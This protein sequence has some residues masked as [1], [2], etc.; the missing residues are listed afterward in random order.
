MQETALEKI[1][2]RIR[3]HPAVYEYY[4]GLY[5]TDTIELSPTDS[6]TLRIKTLL[7]L[8]PKTYK[9][10]NP[11]ANACFL[12]LLMPMQFRFGRNGKKYKTPYRNYLDDRRQRFLARELSK[13]F[14][15]LFL[16][17]VLAFCRAQDYKRGCQKR[18]I[19]DFI[20]CCN[21]SLDKINY[22]MLKKKWNR[23]NQKQKIAKKLGATL[24]PKQN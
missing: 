6:F 20:L 22:E 7:Q 19:E 2:L 23:S 15:D 10:N 18:G 3:V 24:S 13:V 17:H 21:I 8:Q 9:Q 14:D 4:K 12:T 11:F 5:H 1:S 16:Q